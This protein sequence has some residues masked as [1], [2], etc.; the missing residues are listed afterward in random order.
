V[1]LGLLL[2]VTLLAAPRAEATPS[3]TYKCSPAPQD[4]SGWYRSDVSIDW[5]VLPSDATII[6]CE[7]RVYS[8]DTAGTSEFCSADDG[9]A[10]VTVQLKIMVDKTPPV[11]TAGTPS[12]AADL[13]GWYN[14]PVAITFTGSDQTSGIDSCTATTYSGPDSSSAALSGT[15]RDR[16]GNVSLPFPYGLKYDETAP[17]VTGAP[18]ERPANSAGWFNA[19]I[20]FDVQGTDA[21]SGIAHCSSVT[22]AGPDSAAA[23][24]TGTCDD[25]AGNSA[26]RPFSLRYDGTAP[27]VTGAQPGR[28]PN[29]NGWY[30]DAVGIDFSGTDQLSGVRSCTS[31]VYTG[32]D[33]GAASVPGRCTDEAGNVSSSSSFGLKFDATDPF[34]SG[35]Q[36]GRAADANGWYNHPLAVAFAGSD[37]TSGVTACTEASYAGPD[38]ATASVPGTCTDRAGNTSAP[39]SFGLK[40]DESGPSVTAASPARQADANGWYNHSI[41]FVFA[42]TDATSGVAGCAPATYDGPDSGAA[43]VTGQCRDRAGNASSRPFALRYDG[44]PAT[45]TGAT[46]GRSPNDAGWYNR[47]VLLAFN[48]TDQTSGVDA[49]TSLSYDGP[50][51]AA[52]SVA[53]TCT[54]RAG[55][56]SAPRDFGLKYDETA[57]KATGAAPERPPNGLGW[58][59]RQV[60]VGFSGSDATSGVAACASPSY[61]GPDSVAASVLGSCTDRAG[62][63]SG[64]LSF[65]LKYDETVPEVTGAQ[66][67]RSPDRAGWFVEP[68]RFDFTGIDETSGIADCP[69]V[70]FSGPDGANAEV[71]GRCRDRAD[72]TAQRAFSLRFDGNAPEVTELRLVPGDRRLE[73]SW[74]TTADVVSVEVVRTPGIGSETP[75]VVFSGPG[76]TFVDEH[77][78]NDVRYAYRVTV[79]DIAGNTGS[80]TVSGVPTASPAEPVAAGSP[81]MVAAPPGAPRPAARRLIAPA[82]GAIV[83][84]GHPPLLRWTLVRRARYYN[85]QLFRGG[86]KLLT[87]WPYRPRYQLETRWTYAGKPR[88][89]EPGRY[90]WMVWPGY[91]PRSKA[92]YGE[93]I[94]RSTF[95]VKR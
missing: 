20:D 29:A 47:S 94:G 69:S 81:A 90:R 72:N 24:F 50:D 82:P 53:G 8:A 18:P 46:P 76:T 32:P 88:R 43:S 6:G 56:R 48:G 3:V 14:E 77:V 13:N 60:A 34:V 45:A 91:G 73:L 2:L 30:R 84:V 23:S 51:S 12:R 61:D 65:G 87:A 15:C 38:S 59:N 92:D 37:Q 80:R 64:P 62:N 17:T 26:F 9:T 22:Y 7:D 71:L 55:N 44:T 54:D 4:C 67:E 40:Y 95:V 52:V 93:A 35:G 57:P 11:T 41:G 36:P 5:T 10:T 28:G 33:S 19:P 63:V 79:R 27:A 85:V 86:R 78:D 68:V 89:L 1:A 66:A 70:E 49:C 31:V 16:A 25:R 42:A 83:T 21:T 75:T 74:Q 58:Y 39:L